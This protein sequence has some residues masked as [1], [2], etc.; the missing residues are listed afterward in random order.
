MITFYKPNQRNTGSGC[1]IN[2]AY[3]NGKPVFYASLIKQ[4]TTNGRTGTFHENHGNPAASVTI[5][6]NPVEIGGILSSIDQGID[7]STFHDTD[8]QKTGIKFGAYNRQD[9]S[10]K[11]IP[12]FSFSINKT[13]GDLK[14]GIVIGF[15][16]GEARWIREYLVANLQ[17][18]ARH[19][20]KVRRQNGLKQAE[21]DAQAT[22]T[23]TNEAAPSD[24]TVTDET[25]SNWEEDRPEAVRKVEEGWE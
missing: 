25:P 16:L 12:G 23:A 22:E 11:T 15:T 18:A 2:F 14:V 4:A 8:K 9:P 13:A 24:E 7:F 3:Y 5:M 19:L 10:G 21:P 6:L 1:S 20:V 17:D